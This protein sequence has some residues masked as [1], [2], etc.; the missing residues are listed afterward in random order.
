MRNWRHIM[1]SSWHRTSRRRTPWSHWAWPIASLPPHPSTSNQ[2]HRTLTASQWQ[3]THYHSITGALQY[4][5]LMHTTIAYS[6]NQEWLC[7]NS[8]HDRCSL[9]CSLVK[10]ILCYL[11]GTIH[12]DNEVMASSLIELKAYSDAYWVGLPRRTHCVWQNDILWSI[13]RVMRLNI[14]PQQMPS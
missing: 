12:Y 8:P 5:I 6:V 10:G 1:P 9:D 13:D 14:E 7:M 11:W 2:S 3:M 4:L